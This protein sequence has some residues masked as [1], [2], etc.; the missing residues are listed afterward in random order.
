ME[1]AVKSNPNLYLQA[2]SRYGV[3]LGL[4]LIGI[5]T[6]Q[7]LSGLYISMMF[8]I[9]TGSLFIGGL[10]LVIRDFR[11]KSLNGW[12]NYGEGVRIGALSSLLSG[13][14]YGAFMLLLVLV[15]DK[16]YIEEILIQTQEMMEASKIPDDKIEE[17]MDEMQKSSNPW[18]Y[19][20][21]PVLQFGVSGLVISLVAS[22][23]LRKNSENSFDKD[24]Q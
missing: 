9:F 6:I 3:Y 4:L 1:P 15:I 21:A 24:T 7:Y 11:E 10:V 5:Q 20:Y 17:I 22:I 14:L 2:A 18:A 8:S 16:A 23:F 13:F 19:G 12:L